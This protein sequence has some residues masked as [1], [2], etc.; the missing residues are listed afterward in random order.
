MSGFTPGP[1]KDGIE[2]PLK[3]ISCERAGFA[4]VFINTGSPKRDE[5]AQAN[6]RLI[7]A[8]PELL[9]AIEALT[10]NYA[11]VEPGGSKN[12]DKARAAIAKARGTPC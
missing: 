9:E 8:A 12:V 10:A 7:S 5:Q 1:W 3:A 4:L 11:D 6:A 2:I